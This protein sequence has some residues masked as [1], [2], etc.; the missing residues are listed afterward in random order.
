MIVV[1]SSW[2]GPAFIRIK[3]VVPASAQLQNYCYVVDHD[4]KS[5][6]LTVIRRKYFTPHKLFLSLLKLIGVLHKNC[7]HFLNLQSKETSHKRTPIHD[8]ISI[9]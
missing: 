1:V 5:A 4:A 8:S 2:Q 9:Y 7:G 3:R 6:S